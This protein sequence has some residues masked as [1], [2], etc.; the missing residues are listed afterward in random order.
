MMIIK[1]AVRIAPFKLY[2]FLKSLR[3]VSSEQQYTLI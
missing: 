2:D 3:I 1:E